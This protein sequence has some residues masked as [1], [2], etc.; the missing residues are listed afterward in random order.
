LRKIGPCGQWV[1]VKLTVKYN[2]SFAGS[3]EKSEKCR[4]R[5]GWDKYMIRRAS[6]YQ[7][8]TDM[9]P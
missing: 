5:V 2:V 6:I 9:P 3:Q 7:K 4:R 1:T 8:V